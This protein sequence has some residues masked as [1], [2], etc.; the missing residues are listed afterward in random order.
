MYHLMMS[1]FLHLY[2]IFVLFKSVTVPRHVCM[3]EHVDGHVCSHNLSVCFTAHTCVYLIILTS[4][5]RIVRLCRSFHFTWYI[6][7]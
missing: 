2:V 3:L 4:A 7:L 1:A 5:W 6:S